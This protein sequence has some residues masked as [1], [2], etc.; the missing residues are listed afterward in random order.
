[1]W[2]CRGACQ[3]RGMSELG[4]RA[5]LV[6]WRR[7]GVGYESG[8][9][10]GE[11]RRSTIQCDDGS[12]VRGARMKVTIA[13]GQTVDG[14]RI[15]F[16]PVKEPWSEYKLENGTT[17]R[18]KLVMS[19]VVLLDAKDPGGQSQYLARSSNVMSIEEPNTPEEVH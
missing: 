9:V 12:R 1:M 10:D 17:I 19:D 3:R 7:F 16:E 8:F 18:L 5:S 6:R 2:K 13:P 15:G 14:K 4:E 11:S